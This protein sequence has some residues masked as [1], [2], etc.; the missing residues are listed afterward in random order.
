MLHLC[1]NNDKIFEYTPIFYTSWGGV[2]RVYLGLNFKEISRDIRYTYATTATRFSSIFLY[3]IHGV[4]RVYWGVNFKEISHDIRYTYATTAT[5][6]SSF[7]SV[8]H[9][10][11][12]Q[13]IVCTVCI[14]KI[15]KDTK[16][17][18]LGYWYNY[19]W[20]MFRRC[21]RLFS[22]AISRGEKD[23]EFYL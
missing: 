22:R 16:H 7:S 1:N 21:L 14:F 17:T 11:C 12:T 10:W 5:Y 4:Y 20:D 2:Y 6:T 18:N 3:S 19:S 23:Q 13:C 8:Y 9:T 15:V